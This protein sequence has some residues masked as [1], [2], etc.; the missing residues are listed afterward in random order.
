MHTT[1]RINAGIVAGSVAGVFVILFAAF[2]YIRGGSIRSLA[3]RPKN[4]DHDL[5]CTQK[6]SQEGP[7]WVRENL[8]QRGPVNISP[9]LEEARETPESH[10]GDKEQWVDID[11]EDPEL[12]KFQKD[13]GEWLEDWRKRK[14]E[15][16]SKPGPPE[17]QLNPVLPLPPISTRT[18]ETWGKHR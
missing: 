9:D 17:L 7:T 15:M 3:F 8:Q 14:E 13:N 16:M 2:V 11:V 5:L 4:P 10:H 1:G 6:R 18:L 12:G